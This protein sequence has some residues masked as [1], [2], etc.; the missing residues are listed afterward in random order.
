MARVRVRMNSAGAREVLNSEGAQGAC[1]E[2]AEAVRD[3]ACSID[4]GYYEADVQAGR[5]RAHAMVKTPYGDYRTMVL[6]RRNNTL[7]KAIG[8]GG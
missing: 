6:Q 4:G 7:L 8:G 5:N 1:L 2:I 3:R